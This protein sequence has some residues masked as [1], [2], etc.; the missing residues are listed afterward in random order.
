VSTRPVAA[1]LQT[2]I[3][4]KRRLGEGDCEIVGKLFNVDEFLWNA[5][6]NQARFSIQPEPFSQ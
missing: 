4:G 2:S 5:V 3:K 6:E 1:R